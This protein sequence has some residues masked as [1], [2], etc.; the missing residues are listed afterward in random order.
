[1][2]ERELFEQAIR[3]NLSP[4]HVDAA[5]A[6][7]GDY[8]AEYGTVLAWAIWRESR[9]TSPASSVAPLT[10]AAATVPFV[11]AVQS[12]AFLCRTETKRLDAETL[13]ALDLVEDHLVRMRDC[14][15]D[16]DGELRAASPQATDGAIDEGE[17]EEF[18]QT[19]EDFDDN[20]ETST[21]YDVLMYW[22]ER[23]LLSCDHFTVTDKGRALLGQEVAHFATPKNLA[24]DAPES[25]AAQAATDELKCIAHELRTYNP[26]ADE[27]KGE[28]IHKG[29]ARRI[30]SAI[31]AA[32]A[33]DDK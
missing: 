6:M 4:D 11:K 13:K 19:V 16:D 1:M 5:L 3:E 33:E 30:E 24:D 9:R 31:V 15:R 21:P 7:E 32:H 25:P 23:D 20:G 2:T 8:Y 12:L 28:H 17:I 10:R 14:V 29:W 22:A 27:Y 18:R 26:A